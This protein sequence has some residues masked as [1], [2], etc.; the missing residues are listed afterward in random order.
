[1][2]DEFRLATDAENVD[3]KAFARHF[4]HPGEED[5]PTRR[6]VLYVVATMSFPDSG[7]TVRIEPVEGTG[8]EEWMLLED[9]PAFQDRDRTY[10]IACGTTEHEVANVPETVLVRH[11]DQ[12]TRVPVTPW[13]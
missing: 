8:Q 6:A 3:V 13:D 7:W 11:G 5:E 10:L 12:V 9:P 1:M 2:A 4:E